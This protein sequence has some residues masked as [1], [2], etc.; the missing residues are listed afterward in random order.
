[1]S[2][3]NMPSRE[4][5]GISDHKAYFRSAII[6]EYIKRTEIYAW[7]WTSGDISILGGLKSLLTYYRFTRHAYDRFQNNLALIS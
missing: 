7:H 2:L 1:M 3:G 4:T 6:G 5:C